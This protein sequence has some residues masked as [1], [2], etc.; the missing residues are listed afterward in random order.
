MLRLQDEALQRVPQMHKN[1]TALPLQSNFMG[2]ESASSKRVPST[3][4]HVPSNETTTSG[5]KK[6]RSSDSSQSALTLVVPALEVAS[7]AASLLGTPTSRSHN[8]LESAANAPHALPPHA[9]SSGVFYPSGVWIVSPQRVASPPLS[10]TESGSNPSVSAERDTSHSAGSA[11][12][13][14][15][16]AL[17]PAAAPSSH[18]ASGLNSS[19]ASI[20]PGLGDSVTATTG[21]GVGISVTTVASNSAVS[22]A[23]NSVSSGVGR[24]PA[25]DKKLE[26]MEC[27]QMQSS[28]ANELRLIYHGLIG[29]TIDAIPLYFVHNWFGL[30]YKHHHLP[31]NNEGYMNF[32][33][34]FSA[35]DDK[36]QPVDQ[37]SAY[38]S[39][40]RRFFCKK[41]ESIKT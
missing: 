13:T 6:N 30:S 36:Q 24:K 32:R 38:K 14:L 5:K 40:H 16:S 17:T 19:T 4:S 11:V 31:L 22:A 10:T 27:M 12:V 21:S 26:V 25:F 23:S 1:P 33:W 35:F 7:R 20:I 37:H 8:A 15:S 34:P 41:K 3:I 2:N 9:S 39:L 18:L 29:K 28:L